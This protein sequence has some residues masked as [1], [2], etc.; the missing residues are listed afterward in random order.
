[1][2]TLENITHQL[3]IAMQPL[4]DAVSSIESFQRFLYR[5]GWRVDNLPPQYAQLA[6][7]IDAVIT[8]TERLATD[9]DPEEA[10]RLMDDVRQLYQAIKSAKTAPANL[11]DPQTFL[12]ETGERI[13]ELLLI[14]YLVHQR[15]FIYN[16]ASML[17]VI[18]PVFQDANDGRPAFIRQEI[19]WSQ[20]PN[21]IQNPNLIPELVYG[22]GTDDFDFDLFAEHLMEILYACLVSVSLVEVSTNLG[23]NFLGFHESEEGAPKASLGV[24]VPLMYVDIAEQEK[25]LGLC[26]MN[27]PK[28]G[29]K[30]P[31]IVIR[32]YFPS[33][34]TASPF[35][36]DEDWKIRLA[37][38]TNLPG[39]FGIVFRPDHIELTYPGQTGNPLQ[40]GFLFELM[41][42]PSLPL[43]LLGDENGTRLEMKGA[44]IKIGLLMEG[45]DMELVASMNIQDLT[46]VLQSKDADSFISKLLNGSAQR[47]A[48]PLEIEWSNKTGLRFKGNTAF[49]LNFTPNLRFAGISVDEMAFGLIGLNTPVPAARLDATMNMSAK[50]GPIQVAVG[51]MGFQVGALFK[52]GNAGPF[53]LAAGFKP[54][55]G[56]GITINAKAVT[57]GGYL[58]FR[59]EKSEY[60]GVAQLTIKDKISVKAFG[61]LLTK[62]PSGKKG[63]SF[64][65]VVSAEFPPIELGMGFRLTGVGGIVGINRRVELEK[66][67]A[68]LRSNAFDDVLFP[69]AP[70]ENPNGLL[71][72]INEL[73]PPAEGQYVFGFLGQFI[74]GPKGLVNIDLGLVIEFPEPVRLAILGVLKAKVGKKIGEEEHNVLTLQCNF[75][76]VLDFERRFIRFDASLFESTIAGKKI[77]GDLALRVRYGNN[78]DFV[79]TLG[80]FHPVFQPPALELPADLRRLQIMLRS[81][82]PEITVY[83]Y[84]ALTANT[85]QF[86]VAG[87][88]RFEKWG[89]KILGEL[90]FDA[91]FQFSPFRFE[92]TVHFLLAASWKGHDFAAIEMNGLFAGPSPWH[93]EGSLTLKFW[94]FSKTVHLSET[95]GDEDQTQMESIRVQA[96]IVE[97]LTTNQGNWEVATGQ[98]TNSV[99]LARRSTA[100]QPDPNLLL[101]QPNELLT[102]RQ[103]TVPLGIRIDKFGERKPE[104]A[105]KFSLRLLD[106]NGSA[107]KDDPAVQN[108]FAPAQF[109]HLDDE[110]K[111]HAPSYERFDSGVTFKGLDDIDFGDDLIPK[112][113]AVVYEIKVLEPSTKK[114]DSVPKN[115]TENPENFKKSL[116]NNALSNSSFGKRNRPE[117][118]PVIIRERFTVANKADLTG[119]EN[120]RTWSETEARQKL[121]EIEKTKPR[122]AGKLAVLLED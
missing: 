22:W 120:V 76:G 122:M 104:G 27:A 14:D 7:I 4:K 92:V 114:M 67:T 58:E 47:L 35:D 31:G 77:E 44:G 18:R 43:N 48:I 117:R 52:E 80:G 10:L 81:G 6:Q 46:L 83:C 24:L 84:V 21:I 97:D 73:F 61:I 101:F 59:P 112:E 55:S 86:G 94:K 5:L 109:V 89:V 30:L 103:N 111:L 57:G 107:R 19:C 75:F 15:P 63:Y 2:G 70:M 8:K 90:S 105:N 66:L 13:F 65:L 119:Y 68:G 3:G 51:Q 33:E 17:G 121:K 40:I 85:F 56:I 113:V 96:L 23:R 64:I 53:N 88:L 12:A 16:L 38:G 116:Q 29:D 115:A 36:L 91:L 87:V 93:V 42:A 99:T 50:L 34:I 25:M 49:Y 69:T 108:H 60:I 32:P 9:P 79:L 74:W 45:S 41:Y 106:K 82:N 102:V 26:V 100:A 28:V 78:P 1:M 95:W 98:T 39:T 54:P 72:T 110:Q 118:A 11:P 62:L 20:I 37:A 71:N